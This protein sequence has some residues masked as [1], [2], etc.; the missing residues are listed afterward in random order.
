MNKYITFFF[1]SL[2]YVGGF[3]QDERDARYQEEKRRQFQDSLNN[4]NVDVQISGKTHYTDYKIISFNKDSTVVDTTLS[5]Q[6]DYIF[7]FLRKDDFEK[8]FFH[9]QGQTY[10][11][12]GYHFTDTDVFPEMGYR[13]KHF[14]YYELEDVDYYHVPTPTSELM[15]KTALEQGQVLDA[16]ITFN[17]SKRHNLSLGYKGLR[18]LGKYRNSLA[19]HGNMRFTYSFASKNEAYHLRTHITAQDLM[20]TENGGLT[21]ASLVNFTNE[22]KNFRDR[23]RMEVNFDGTTTFLRGNRYY[24]DH[25]YAI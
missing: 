2:C 1:L 3:A 25:D 20:N 15:Y 17:T 5:M 11:S 10:N 18:S 24:L 21:P 7:N 16:F 22:D 9:N 23:G 13:A 4:R 6:K 12:L 14:N 8:L 19:S